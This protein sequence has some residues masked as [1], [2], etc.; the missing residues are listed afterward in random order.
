MLEKAGSIEQLPA[1]PRFVAYFTAKASWAFLLP[2]PSR[3]ELA[4]VEL[5]T[6]DSL[7]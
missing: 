7:A 3:E 5:M 6:L 1:T 2:V 4:D